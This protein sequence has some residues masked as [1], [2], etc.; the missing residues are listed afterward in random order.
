MKIL[1][2]LG[3][4]GCG[5]VY[6]VM[7]INDCSTDESDEM[8]SMQASGGNTFGWTAALKVEATRPD[9][10]HETLRIEVWNLAGFKNY[11][12]KILLNTFLV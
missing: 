7:R 8:N 10:R 1:D 5:V 6:R 3:A 12:F 9:K 2:E 4:G 11:F